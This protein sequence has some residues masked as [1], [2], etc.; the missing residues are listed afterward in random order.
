MLQTI[1]VEIDASGHI[2]PLEPLSFTPLGRAYLTLLPVAA[3]T[4]AD[5][6]VSGSAVQALKLLTSPRFAKR[7]VADLNEVQQRINSLRN[8]WGE[9]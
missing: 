7:P 8:E 5:Q 1:E 9:Q 3:A 6:S 4:N 2:H